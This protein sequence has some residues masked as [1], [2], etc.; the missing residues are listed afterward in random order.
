M[1][2]QVFIGID[3]SAQTLDICIKIGAVSESLVIDNQSKIVKRFLKQFAS[4][5]VFIGMENTGRYNWP[6]YEALASFKFA[7]YVINPV[8]L[9]KSLGLIRGKSD[10]IDAERIVNFIMKNSQDLQ[11][12]EQPS[13]T[14]EK[15]KVLLAERSFRIKN[16]KQLQ[17]MQHDY[18]RMKVIGLE[19]SLHK[20]NQQLIDN[21]NQQIKE[22]EK[23]IE[24]LV[25]SDET[26]AKQAKLIRSVP[27][28]GKVLSWNMLTK[29][30]GFKSIKTPRK[31]ACYAG[32][33]PFEHQSGTSVWRK[34]KVSVYADK[35][36]KSLLHL[37][38][39]SA[40]RLKNDLR[41]YYLRKVQDGKNKM[42]VL[43]AVRNKIIQR[44]YAVIKN[45][46]LYRNNLALS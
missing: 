12:W 44:V 35:S 6:I 34:P 46:T 24:Q 23:E 20:R 45:Q 14:I 39:M 28:V 9:K 33:V 11:Q 26:L 41:V 36:L 30:N 27:G 22:L 1:K 19:K 29:T 21:L 25:V 13:V 2:K 4:D 7:V 17:A 43:N 5:E 31:L 40:I 3:V 16:K 15:L 8:H 42:L 10:K 38:A 18:K 37:A 32:V